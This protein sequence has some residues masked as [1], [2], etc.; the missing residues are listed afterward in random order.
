MISGSAAITIAAEASFNMV[1]E[2]A[3]R[4]KVFIPML[5]SVYKS[6]FGE[7]PKSVENRMSNM[8][9]KSRT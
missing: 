6:A 3:G 8:V 4:E 1:L 2:A 5:G 9:K 7:L